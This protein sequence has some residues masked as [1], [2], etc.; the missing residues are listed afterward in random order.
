MENLGLLLGS[1]LAY[2]SFLLPA[3]ML[4]LST[5]FWRRTKE[6]AV[7]CFKSSYIAAFDVDSELAEVAM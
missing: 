2:S 3:N 5:P 7:R 1:K 4:V 6:A